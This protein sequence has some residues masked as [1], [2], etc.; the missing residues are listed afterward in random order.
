MT[1]MKYYRHISAAT[2]TQHNQSAPPLTELHNY[3]VNIL[4]P[5]PRWTVVNTGR[6]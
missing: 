3:R 1:E 5:P 2:R 6:D 4:L